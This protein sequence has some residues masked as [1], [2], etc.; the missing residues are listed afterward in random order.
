MRGLSRRQRSDIHRAALAK[1][2]DAGLFV[3]EPRLTATRRPLHVS[4]V[5]I[6]DAAVSTLI[7]IFDVLGSLYLLADFAFRMHRRR[8]LLS[9][10]C[11]GVFL[12]AETGLFDGKPSTVHWLRRAGKRGPAA[13]PRDVVGWRGQHPGL[14]T[15]LGAAAPSALAYPGRLDGRQAG[16]RPPDLA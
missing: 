6:P 8:A 7:G 1:E 15:A 13:H 10:A 9:P 14:G 2:P 4:L 11:S 3:P 5:A 16:A 12:L